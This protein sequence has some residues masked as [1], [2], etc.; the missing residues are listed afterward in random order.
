MRQT[1][2]AHAHAGFAGTRVLAATALALA[3]LLGVL[4]QTNAAAAA[5][6]AP[7]PLA[8]AA[9]PA[10]SEGIVRVGHFGPHKHGHGYK[11]KKHHGVKKFGFKHGRGFKHGH[12]YKYR[13]GYKHG[14]GFKRG[15]GV[16]VFRFGGFGFKKGFGFKHH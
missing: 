7:A 3:A 11:F 6:I 14:H 2:S 10:A 1:S 13:H 12:G 4:A 9:Q 8:L 15:H 16:K 5:P